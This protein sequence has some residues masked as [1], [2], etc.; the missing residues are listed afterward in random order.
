[1][2]VDNRG[3]PRVYRQ[4]C[5][6]KFN[7]FF[8][9]SV[10]VRDL[11]LSFFAA[12]FL[13]ISPC[14]CWVREF[15]VFN[16]KWSDKYFTAWLKTSSQWEDIHWLHLALEICTKLLLICKHTILTRHR[17]GEFQ[18]FLPKKL[19]LHS[20]DFTKLIFRKVITLWQE[21]FAFY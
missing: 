5:S 20:L 21:T 2:L 6:L 18:S 16:W 4:I 8:F 1:M 14:Q 3:C 19:I 9:Y 15:R 13:P 10:W 11:K 12:V 17:N 7:G